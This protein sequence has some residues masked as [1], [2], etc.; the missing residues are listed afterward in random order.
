MANQDAAFGL[1][2]LRTVGQQDDS[3]G[4]SSHWI[5]AAD[6]SAMYQGSLVKCPASSTG[7]I[8][9]SA[10]GDVLN[11]GAL[12]G[13]FYNDPT[14]LKPTFKNYYPGSITPPGGKDIEAFVYDSPYQMFEV[15]SAASGASA[16]A[17]IF[18]CCDI[19]SN[20]GS[21]T[22]GVSSLESADSFSAQAQLKV[23]GVSRDPENDEIGA[24]NVNW[25]V[26]VNEHLFGSGSAGG[27]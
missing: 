15:Q 6:A 8:D 2:P 7:Y 12:W 16:Q 26:M 11:V 21:T 1:R 24:A 27:A 10:A 3:T 14:T 25:R 5:D 20:A 17:D 13:V 9:I 4:M 18:M 22:N 23:I 19:A